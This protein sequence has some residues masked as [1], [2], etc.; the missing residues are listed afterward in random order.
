MNFISNTLNSIV[1]KLTKQQR[2]A[3]ISAL[4]VGFIS[5]GY[6]MTHNYIY[7]DATILD[8][9][10]STFELGRWALGLSG[11]LNNLVLANYHL[12]FLNVAVS[13]LFIALA[14][15]VVVDVLLVRSNF[16]AVVIG[17]LMVSYPVVTSSFA[18]NFTAA[19]YFLALFLA[20]CAVKVLKDKKDIKLIIISAILIAFSAGFYQAYISVTATLFVSCMLIDLYGGEDFMEEIGKGIRYLASLVLGLALYM[21]L[22]KVFM[23]IFKPYQT[24]YQGMEEFGKLSIA[25][26]PSK[27]LEAYMHF[28]YVKWNGIN[29]SLVMWA[30]IGL[31]ILLAVITVIKGL[32]SKEIKAASKLLFIL[33]VFIYPI[34]VNVVYIMSTSDDYSVHTLMRYAT[35]FVLILPAVFL[36]KNTSV[37]AVFGEIIL[38]L[39]SIFYIYVN[40]TA[41]LKMNLVQEEMTSYLTVLQSRITS[42]EYY[43]DNMPVVFVGQFAIDDMNLTKM[44]ETYPDIQF[45]G[46]EYDAIELLN[47][48]SWLRYMRIHTGYEPELG[49]L[50]DDIRYSDEYAEMPNYPDAGS[51]KV[52][53]G[54]V[55]VKFY[56]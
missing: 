23:L 37:L 31:L 21:V 14:A 56:D 52:I 19:Y 46:Y 54:R 1:S 53:N 55:V 27:L 33:L 22:S 12:P 34:A 20:V 8:G 40:N 17:S 39:I 15:M 44:T 36:E 16:L 51:V 38:V 10:G 28:F 29:S 6:G 9:L 25:K 35:L 41:Y 49:E 3:F 43:D 50:T 32:L 48:E 7:H 42:A 13:I 26:F 30:F 45:L 2:L 4:I 47:K 24:S 11:L 5:H 18:Y